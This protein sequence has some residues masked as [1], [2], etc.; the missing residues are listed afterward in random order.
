M[1]GRVICI[2]G[3]VL[4][5]LIKLYYGEGGEE[6]KPPEQK[7]K[8]LYILSVLDIY[9]EATVIE[10][11]EPQSQPQPEPQP[12]P[13]SEPATVLVVPQSPS[14]IRKKFQ[15]ASSFE[16]GFTRSS[17]IEDCKLPTLIDLTL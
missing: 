10:H 13:L 9:R 8:Y 2:E 16:R 3:E 4:D 7:Y 11:L 14:E 12:E 17:E 15:Q 6:E 5:M 1:E